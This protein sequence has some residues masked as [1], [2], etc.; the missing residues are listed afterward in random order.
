M[1][2]GRQLWRKVDMAI[3][4]V[5]NPAQTGRAVAEPDKVLAEESR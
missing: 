3:S 2:Q 1:A 4:M 5:G